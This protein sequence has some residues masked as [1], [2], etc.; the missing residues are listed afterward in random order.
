MGLTVWLG[1]I[2]ADGARG[3][4]TTDLRMAFILEKLACQQFR[5]ACPDLPA[6]DCG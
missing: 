6:Y 5:R 4:Y 1:D 3:G 2:A